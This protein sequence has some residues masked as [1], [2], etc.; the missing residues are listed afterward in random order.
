VA[1]VAT[2]ALLGAIAALFSQWRFSFLLVAG[3]LAYTAKLLATPDLRLG[4]ASLTFA[5]DV[6]LELGAC[7]A[8]GHA[9]FVLIGRKRAAPA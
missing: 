1:N 4:S 3:M 6:A 7:Y 8:A 2:F 9:V 5:L